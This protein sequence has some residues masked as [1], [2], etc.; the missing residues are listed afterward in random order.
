MNHVLEIFAFF[1]FMGI[2]TSFCIPETKRK[3]L[4]ELN[5]EEYVAEP[6]ESGYSTDKVR[7]EVEARSF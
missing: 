1:M 4:E 3:T 5:G 7:P 6:S 2:L